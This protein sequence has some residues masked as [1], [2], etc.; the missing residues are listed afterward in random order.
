MADLVAKADKKLRGGGL[1]SFFSGPPYD[2][3]QE[4]YE[5]ACNQLK[6]EKN[7]QLAAE[8]Y[9]TK[10]THVAEQGGAPRFQRAN[11]FVEGGKCLQKASLNI[12]PALQ[13]FNT[14]ITLWGQDGKYMQSGKQLKTIAETLEEEQMGTDDENMIKEYYQRA[15]DMFE[16]DDYGKSLL[17]QCKLKLADFSSRSGDYKAAIMV[18]ESEARAC[19]SNNLRQYGAKDLF[20]QAGVLHMVM[21]DLITC[22]IQRDRYASEDPRFASSMEGALFSKLLAAIEGNDEKAFTEAL[23]DYDD[24]KPLEPWFVT[25]L[26]TVKANFFGIGAKVGG[27]AMNDFVDDGPDDDGLD[28]S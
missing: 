27:G 24:T 3:C 23:G 18:Y 8:V 12:K 11:Y 16:M 14:A 15:C 4:L 21:G 25:H 2:E 17:S 7:F 6:L 5:Q 20:W 13:A 10:L 22:K 19:L 1:M 28:L 26:Q 9:L